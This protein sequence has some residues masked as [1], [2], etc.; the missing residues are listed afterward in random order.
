MGVNSTAKLDKSMSEEQ[1]NEVVTAILNGKYSWAC[2]L[3]LRFAGYNPLHYIPYRTYNRLM[4][5]NTVPIKS[6]LQ[7]KQNTE[8]FSQQEACFNQLEDLGYLETLHE[9]SIQV[10]GGHRREWCDRLLALSH[11]LKW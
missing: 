6:Q 5:E 8:P 4:K 11:Y 10:N 3:I 7:A 2:L 1:F 9:Q